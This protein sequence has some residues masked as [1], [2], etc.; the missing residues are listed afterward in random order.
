MIVYFTSEHCTT[1]PVVSISFQNLRGKGAVLRAQREILY[2]LQSLTRQAH[3]YCHTRIFRPKP[4]KK[5]IVSGHPTD[6]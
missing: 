4:P 5:S 1:R 2:R 6:P 3:N